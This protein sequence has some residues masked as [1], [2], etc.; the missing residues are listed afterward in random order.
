MA[1]QIE[2]NSDLM[3]EFLGLEQQLFLNEILRI[4]EE[5]FP[6]VRIVNSK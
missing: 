5:H 1:S 2:N 4:V 6:Y 3:R